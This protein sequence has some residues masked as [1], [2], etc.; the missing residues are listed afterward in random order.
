MG[1]PIRISA[2]AL[3]AFAPL[4]SQAEARSN[5][6]VNFVERFGLLDQDRWQVS[7]GWRN[8]AWTANDWDAEQVSLRGQDLTIELERRSGGD[9]PFTSGELQSREL[10]KHGYFE[11][12]LRA[13]R[14]SGL[15]SGFFTYARPDENGHWDEIDI[16]ILGRDTTQVQFTTFHGGVHRAVT[17][18]LGFDAA[19][20]HHTYGFEWLPGRVRWYVD[21]QLMH[22]ARGE[23]VPQAPQRLISHLWNSATLTDWLG[24]IEQHRN[25]WTL[26]IDCIANAERFTGASLCAPAPKTP[27]LLFAARED[28][29]RT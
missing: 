18:P 21:G 14:G 29:K 3:A 20:G 5:E 15:V 22:E 28:V 17:L 4:A 7:D 13:P 25:S 8:G 6:A 19:E 9:D 24:P 26:S 10:Y 12:R 1:T 11:V 27:A 23:D 2:L 16:E